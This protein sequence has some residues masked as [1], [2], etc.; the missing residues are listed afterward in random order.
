VRLRSDMV[1]WGDERTRPISGMVY[2]NFTLTQARAE[3]HCHE[4]AWTIC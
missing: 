2:P 1:D 4:A 3:P